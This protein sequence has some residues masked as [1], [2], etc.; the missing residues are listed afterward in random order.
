MASSLT[1]TG[2]TVRATAGPRAAAA[3]SA[4]RALARAAPCAPALAALHRGGLPSSNK[5]DSSI[6]AAPR[7]V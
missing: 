2:R 5:R 6:A 7:C 1:L 3:S 4:P